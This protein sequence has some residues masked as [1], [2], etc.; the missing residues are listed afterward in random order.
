ML[1]RSLHVTALFLFFAVRSVFG[2]AGTADLTGIVSD[3]A[4]A[5][6]AA[7]KVTATDTETR[8]STETQTGAGG[9]YVFT[10]LRPSVYEVSAEANGFQRLVRTGVTLVTGERTRVDLTLVVGSVKESVT[11]SG[12]APLLQTESGSITQSIDNEKIVELPLNGRNFIQL[13]TLSPGV[14]LPPGTQL[15]RINGGRPRTNEYLFDGISALQPEP[16]QVVFFPIIDAI[17][18]FNVQTNAVSAE[19]GRFNGGVVNLATRSGSNEFHGSVYE[20]FRNES[21]NA[22]NYFAP[23]GQRKPEFR[24]NQYG[25]TLGGPIVKNRTF[26][27]VDYQGA[28]QAIGTVRTSTV[29]TLLERQ[30]NFTELYGST[31]PVLYDPA[32]TVQN[33]SKFTRS[34]FAPT[35]VIPVDRIDPAA[36][37]ALNHYPLPTKSGTSNNFTL[38]DNDQDHQN[39]FDTRIDHKFSDHNQTFGR[40]SYF[41]DV[42][43]PVPFLPD[44][45]GNITTGAIG[46]TDTLGQQVVGSYI[47]TFSSKTLNDLRGG[48]TRRSF[49]RRGVQLGSS[50]SESLQIPGIPTNG[51]FNNAL[52]LF[53]IAGYQQIGS[54][55]NTN[56]NFRTD[57]TELV[58]SFSRLLGNHAIKLG[59]DFRWERLDVIQPPNPTG[60]FTFSQLFTDQPGVKSTG[61]PLASFLLGQVQQFSIDLQ[62][63]I[64]RPRAHIQEYFVQ[65]DWKVTRRLTVNGGVRWTLNFPST[66]VDNQGAIFNTKTQQ[67]DYLGKNGYPHTARELH[68]HDFAPRLGLAYML[69]DKTVLRAG[70]GLVWIE[71]TG[72]TTPFTVPQ[73]PFLQTTSQRTLD[74]INPA[75]VLS[76]GP[77]VAP[78]PLTPDAG[79][80]QGVFTVN[81]DLGSGYTQQW[82]LAVQ[83]ELTRNMSLEVAYVGSHITHVGIPD[84]NINQ[85]SVDQLAT[86]SPLLQKVTNPFF[87]QIPRSSSL[88]DPSIAAGQLLKPFPEFLTVAPYRNNVGSTVY[89]GFEAKLEQRL[90]HGLSYLV[91]YTHSKLIDTASSVFDASILT[92]PIANF[93]V[94]DSFNLRR[95]R[96]SSTG[97]IPN[98]FVASSTWQL[99]VG[100]GH[101]LNPSGVWGVLA[102]GWQITGIVQLQSGMPFAITQSTNFNAFAG[103]GVQRPNVVASP[104]LPSNQRSPAKWFNTAAFQAAPQFT[105]G[106][107]SRNPVRGPDY[108]DAD[109][110]FIKHTGI[111]E[112]VD[113]EFRAEIFNLTNTPAF[114]QPNGVVGS[115][116]F[117]TI[118][119]TATD[120]RVIQFALKVNY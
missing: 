58:D 33:G 42:D 39:Q 83:R 88:G 112:R 93:P 84:V 57:V 79:L 2:Q 77:N 95:E 76:T 67:L 8:V 72:I 55:S 96:D 108:R 41:H 80:G 34:S 44:G 17:Q 120:P 36:L 5:L 110:A 98:V 31:T 115:S 94:A 40:Y 66:E 51:A 119:T 116:A 90:A 28:K 48:Y 3:S 65:D 107:A 106:N 91:S 26:F 59:L 78:I 25:A 109:I 101:S 82:N 62:E 71:Q 13:A 75:F 29:P 35:N 61:D 102:N 30:G 60:L 9:V 103:F 4:G 64:L 87:G 99:P 54:P 49:Q 24:R 37:A 92:G 111:R 1:K 113:L 100:R 52:P 89:H 38:V 14:T 114:G 68:W 70:Y 12:D 23:V 53:N 43:Q 74:N 6:L 15:P 118:T 117:G 19:F 32:T 21:L 11:V 20:F 18:E 27:F 97:D 81:R 22:R 63:K 45:S 46:L 47:H 86:G 50:P 7:A 73:F 16:G 104:N 69:Q 56:S 105:L 10:N 85:L